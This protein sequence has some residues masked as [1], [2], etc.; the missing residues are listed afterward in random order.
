M[1]SDY[2][3]GRT[4]ENGTGTGNA[5]GYFKVVCGVSRSWQLARCF[6]WYKILSQKACFRSRCACCIQ[7]SI[8]LRLD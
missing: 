5:E 6:H 3:G 7:F 8:L 1:D 4:L 2:T